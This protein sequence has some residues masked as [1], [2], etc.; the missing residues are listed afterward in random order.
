MMWLRRAGRFV[1]LASAV[2][3]AA[4]IA[5]PVSAAEAPGTPLAIPVI[6]S[7]TGPAA[8]LGKQEADALKLLETTTNKSG[9]VNRRAIHFD[10]QDD[11]S[12][13]QVAVQLTTALIASGA[14][15]ILGSDVASSCAAMAPLAKA[16]GPVM[17]CF[18]PAVIG[19]TA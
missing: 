10:I 7:L 8:F 11:E 5:A 3:L 2:L 16:G 12:S 6:L 19:T 17:Y 18:S 13:P 1:E 9:G 15:V 4:S 14:Q